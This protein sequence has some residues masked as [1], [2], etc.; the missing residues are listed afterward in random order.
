MTALKTAAI[1][2]ELWWHVLPLFDKNVIICFRALV[3]TDVDKFLEGDVFYYAAKQAL[4]EGVTDPLP[5]FEQRLGFMPYGSWDYHAVI[6]MKKLQSLIYLSQ[7]GVQLSKLCMLMACK[8]DDP[9]IVGVVYSTIPPCTSFDVDILLYCMMHGKLNAAKLLTEMCDYKNMKRD[10]NFLDS[11]A[12]ATP[13]NKS[14]WE[15]C[16]WLID[17]FQFTE[18]EYLYIHHLSEV[19]PRTHRNFCQMYKAYL[20][21]KAQLSETLG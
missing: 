5:Y 1:P 16:F 6:N 4:K 2:I 17:Y 10:M 18:S 9:V 12:S 19:F 3:G 14:T 13:S 11:F 15:T 20:S 21:R 7:K 8:L